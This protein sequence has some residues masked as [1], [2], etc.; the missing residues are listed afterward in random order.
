MIGPGGACSVTLVRLRRFSVQ[1]F[2]NLEQP[3][4]LDDLGPINVLHGANNVGKSNL[5]QAIEL[6]F[7]C[8]VLGISGA[9]FSLNPQNLPGFPEP[10]FF[11]H[12]ERPAPIALSAIIDAQ[13]DE[14]RV[15][16]IRKPITEVMIDIAIVLKPDGLIKCEIKR[17]LPGMRSLGDVRWGDFLSQLAWKSGVSTTAPRFALVGVRRDLEQD[18]VLYGGA[19][20]P[21]AQEMYSCRDSLD[22][23][24]RNR[25]RSFVRA[26]EE[27][28]EI[29][30]EGVFEVIRPEA[31][32]SLVFDTEGM[33]I[34]LTL[35]GSGVQQIASLLGNALVRNAS[36]VGIEEP[37]LN[38]RWDL[39]N[40]LRSALSSI[41]S[42]PHGTGG[43][44]QIFITSHSPAFETSD[45]FWLMEAGPK[46]PTLSRRPASELSVVLGS[47]PQHLSL[48]ERAPQ[49]YVT[50]QGVIRLPPRVIERLHLDKGGGVVFVDTEP[51]GVR[52]LSDDD[53][54]DE[55]GLTDGAGPSDVER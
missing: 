51:R 12:L 3:I 42:E 26:M 45:S 1:G 9:E 21:L 46:G 43:V 14:I 44:D 17:A 2:K 40:K 20:A 49:A 32:A 50:S 36:I 27:L 16:G 33:R 29:T 13:P 37:E 5:L 11:F 47:A 52:L 24:K 18:P 6:F 28:K 25:W 39:Q 19:S 23:G 8:V 30:G 38:L 55:L 7:R 53:Y 10:R 35:L 48:P 4:V 15:D 54:L 22:R 31:K 41:V 34:P